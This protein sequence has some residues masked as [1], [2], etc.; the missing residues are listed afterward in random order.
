MAEEPVTFVKHA[1][2]RPDEPRHFMRIKPVN[3]VVVAQVKN[4][5]IVRSEKTLKLQEAGF[6]LYDPVYYF[7][8]SAFAEGMLA[9]ANHSTHCPLKG[10]TE[11]YH[12]TIGGETYNFAAFCY[13]Y[14][15]MEE[16]QVLQDYIAFDQ[17]QVQVFEYLPAG[18]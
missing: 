8:K 14:P 4:E 16:T 6:D 9:L 7:P 17:S 18:S 5:V 13:N 3:G 11:Y 12:L 10:D 2:H 15:N 1:I